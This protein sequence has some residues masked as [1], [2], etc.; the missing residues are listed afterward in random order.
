MNHRQHDVVRLIGVALLLLAL[1]WL[2]GKVLKW[3]VIVLIS[4]TGGGLA[5]VVLALEANRR[6]WL[7][8]S[9]RP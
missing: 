2:A 1:L 7:A 5:L 3:A 6:G 8:V 4:T 9:K